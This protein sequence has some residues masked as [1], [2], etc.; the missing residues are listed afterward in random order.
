MNNQIYEDYKQTLIDNI[1]QKRERELNKR[2][3]SQLE[4]I[5]GEI[6]GNLIE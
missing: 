2:N 5:L 6:G 3:I 4:I 1:I